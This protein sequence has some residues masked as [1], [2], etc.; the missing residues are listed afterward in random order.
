MT[1]GAAGGDRELSPRH[2]HLAAALL[3]LL[4]HLH[5]FALL[6]QTH[7]VYCSAHAA[8]SIARCAAQVQ[9]LS[10]T[11]EALQTDYLDM[12][13]IH[14]PFLP[15]HVDLQQVR[16]CVACAHQSGCVV[17]LLVRI[18]RGV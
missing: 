14:A 15:P 16:S 1:R 5:V 7:T 2:H 9:A 10:R 11:L 6:L 13:L 12:Y 4:Y 8:A 17:V 3:F 18:N